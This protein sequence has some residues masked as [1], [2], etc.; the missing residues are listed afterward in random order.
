MVS[1]RCKMIVKQELQNIG[2]HY[3]NVD[4]GT[5]E[6]LENIGD[7]QREQLSKNLKTFGLELLDD[8]RKILIEKIKAV[9]IEMIH[10]T[11][12]LPKVNYS[13]YISEKLG[14]DYTYLANTFSEVKGITIQQYIIINK[15]ERVKEL[16]LYD[17]LNLTEISYQLHY[18]SVAHLSNQ[19]K[20][21]TGL[22]PSFFK[23]LKKKRFENIEDL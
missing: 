18:S 6:I 9:I 21:I 23:K 20:K 11:D 12:E 1:L 3:V 16:L 14:Y 10:Y 4:L 15:I 7:H 17:E 8:K 5:I 19:F 22:T 2:L 13:D